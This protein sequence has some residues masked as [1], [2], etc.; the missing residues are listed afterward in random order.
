MHA[1]YAP[2]FLLLF[3]SLTIAALFFLGAS[4]LGKKKTTPEKMLPFECGS[5]STGAN[6]VRLQVKFYLTALLFVVF[7]VEAVFIYPWA[8]EFRSLGWIGFSSMVAFLSVMLVVLIYVWRKG[9]LEWE[10]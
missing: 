10:S 9:A 1:M 2:I 3:I 7:D 6:H 5:E 4:I 8:V